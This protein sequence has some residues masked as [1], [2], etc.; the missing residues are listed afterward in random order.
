MSNYRRSTISDP[1]ARGTLAR[2][3]GETHETAL[4]WYHKSLLN[5]GLAVMS[6]TGPSVRYT[7]D[8]RRRKAVPEVV[9]KGPCDY[10][11]AAGGVGVYF[12]AKSLS[13]P[14]GWTIPEDRIHQRDFLQNVYEVSGGRLP[15]FYLV[16]WREH[17][18]GRIHPIETIWPGKRI[19]YE[20]GIPVPELVQ[21]YGPVSTY[22]GL[23]SII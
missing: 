22:Y 7:Y 19:R 6:K 21:W 17:G 1:V 11:G 8:K 2:D 23:G 12:E 4:E 3:A 9:G 20:D 13:E 5:R 14:Q 10:I 16:L 15:A 18:E